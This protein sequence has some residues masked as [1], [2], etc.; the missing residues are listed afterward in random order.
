MFGIFRVGVHPF[1]EN[2][3]LSRLI[4]FIYTSDQQPPKNNHF[5]IFGTC[6]SARASHPLLP[7]EE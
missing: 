1:L 4:F 7:L 5:L 2:L 3:K 6:S